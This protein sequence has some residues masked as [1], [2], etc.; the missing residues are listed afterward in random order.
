MEGV[1]AVRKK[2]QGLVNLAAPA[3]QAQLQ[4]I[5]NT[6]K[7]APRRHHQRQQQQQQPQAFFQSPVSK[8]NIPLVTGF[9][10]CGPAGSPYAVV[11]VTVREGSRLTKPE[12][13]RPI[14]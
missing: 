3:E 13:V 14:N 5:L 11:P 6:G 2:K 4:G 7:P 10:R 12:C 1:V 8:L 9:C